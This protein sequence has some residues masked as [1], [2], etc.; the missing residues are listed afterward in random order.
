MNSLA[1]TEQLIDLW[2]FAEQPCWT[3]EWFELYFGPWMKIDLDFVSAIESEFV[4][5]FV[6]RF[7]SGSGFGSESESGSEIRKMLSE[8]PQQMIG[9]KSESQQQQKRA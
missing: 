1:L 5:Q 2:N 9:L 6:T 7:E 3:V 8:L 4:T